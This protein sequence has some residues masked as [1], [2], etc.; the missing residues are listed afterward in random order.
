MRPDPVPYMDDEEIDYRPPWSMSSQA[1]AAPRP[2][3]SGRPARILLAEDEPDMRDMLASALTA[4]G[5][6]VV[7]AENGAML[8]EEIGLLLYRGEAI[9]ADLIISD[10]R[11]PG[12]LGSEILSAIRR[13]R[14]PTPFILITAFGDEALHKRAEALGASVVVDKP[15]DIDVFRQIVLSVLL[16]EGRSGPPGRQDR[17]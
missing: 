11:M 6:E 3:V 14:W 15:F 4:D 7:V 13:A 9:P 1:G 17:R 5:F 10:E 12:M 8:F 2:L 16:R